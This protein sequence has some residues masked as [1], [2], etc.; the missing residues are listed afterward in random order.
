MRATLV[1][2]HASLESWDNRY[3]RSVITGNET[4]VSLEMGH[5]LIHVTALREYRLFHDSN[6]S[7]SMMRVTPIVLSS[8]TRVLEVRQVKGGGAEVG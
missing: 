4:R 8:P 7:C 2:E 5:N 1:I 6:K 3:E